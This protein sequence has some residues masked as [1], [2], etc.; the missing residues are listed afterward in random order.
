MRVWLK[1][2]VKKESRRWVGQ[3][4]DSLEA[5]LLRWMATPLNE[6]IGGF[7]HEAAAADPRNP[8]EFEVRPD[9]DAKL[10]RRVGFGLLV[11]TPGVAGASRHRIRTKA[12][13]KDLDS[14][15]MLVDRITFPWGTF[16]EREPID[17][18][19]ARD[20]ERRLRE[21]VGRE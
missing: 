9:V 19:Q 6:R 5:A 8:T 17:A 14:D 12:Q 11:V 20:F 7:I 3:S 1:T 4:Y 16:D 15:Y 13:D 10:R 21:H 2:L 18:A